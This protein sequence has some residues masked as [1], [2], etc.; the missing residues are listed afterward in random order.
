MFRIN[1]SFDLKVNNYSDTSL[2]YAQIKCA[3]FYRCFYIT[4]S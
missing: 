4:A 1:S 3:R 2:I